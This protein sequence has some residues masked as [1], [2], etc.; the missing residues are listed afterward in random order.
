MDE[1]R[2][3]R[4][5]HVIHFKWAVADVYVISVRMS[6]DVPAPRAILVG[7]APKQYR[8]QDVGDVPDLESSEVVVQICIKRR[9]VDSGDIDALDPVGAPDMEGG[10]FCHGV[11]VS[12]VENINV[13]PGSGDVDHV[14]VN[15]YIQWPARRTLVFAHEDDVPW[16]GYIVTDKRRVALVEDGVDKRPAVSLLYGAVTGGSPCHVDVPSESGLG[17]AEHHKRPH[18]A[19]QGIACNV[20]HGNPD[21]VAT[22]YERCGG[23][24]GETVGLYRCRTGDIFAVHHNP[25]RSHGDAG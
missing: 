12:S 8:R 10:D 19:C 9:S 14:F 13:S 25:H 20:V 4:V 3:S 15:D 24:V 17:V 21:V 18:G 5:P 6:P 2:C 22:V 23:N 11:G 1:C 16:I 7:K